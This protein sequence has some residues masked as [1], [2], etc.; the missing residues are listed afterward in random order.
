MPSMK[1]EQDVTKD[2]DAASDI[3]VTAEPDDRIEISGQAGIF[4]RISLV[5]LPDPPTGWVPKSTVSFADPPAQPIVEEEFARECWRSAIYAGVNP[6][7]M[8]AVAKMRSGVK[9]DADATGLGPFRL[10]QAEWDADWNGA[11]LGY[12]YDARDIGNWRSQCSMFALM[13]RRTIEQIAAGGSGQPSARDL[14]L[15]QIIGAKAAAAVK[16]DPSK[17]ILSGIAP[18]DLPRG[19]PASTGLIDRYSGLL[20]SAG[21]AAT[22]QQAV[23]AITSS[24]KQALEATKQ[25]ILAGGQSVL[26]APV[27]VAPESE[28]PQTSAAALSVQDVDYSEYHGVV[29]IDTWIAKACKAAGLPPN[30]FW[31]QGY[32]T[33]CRR[34]SSNDPN[35]INK[36]DSNAHG[37]IVGD[38][39]PQG[40]SRGVAQCIPSTFASYH[41]AQTAK[42]IYDPVANIAAS[43]KYVCHRYNVSENGSNLAARVQQ[44]DE[45]RDPK[46]Y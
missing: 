16:E 44:A 23:D 33:L 15:A 31:L 41:V 18:G 35:N 45:G 13:V 4:F 20:K 38:G 3:V 37:P 7:Y 42:S 36:N 19:N 40:C 28:L 27:L 32:K 29:E 5:D 26:D 1:T 30:N 43:M 14:Y 2:P 6:H 22:G 12:Q 46:G 24:L 8:M 11:A 39:F 10:L 25:L 34:E 9:N 17:T 21:V